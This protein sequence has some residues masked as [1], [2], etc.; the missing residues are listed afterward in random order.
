MKLYDTFDA[1]FFGNIPLCNI[2]FFIFRLSQGNVATLVRWSGW[3]S[4]RH[5]CRSSLNL[6]VKKWKLH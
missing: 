5:M 6:T 2:T 4:Y 3:S 1:I